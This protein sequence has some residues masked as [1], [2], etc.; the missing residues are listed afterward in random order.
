VPA[1]ICG[2]FEVSEPQRERDLA[3]DGLLRLRKQVYRAL[4]E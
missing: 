1:K 4:T 3:S 2:R